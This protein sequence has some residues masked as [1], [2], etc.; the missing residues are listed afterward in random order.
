MK[1]ESKMTVQ[2][3]ENGLIL[4]MAM[5]M[6]TWIIAG[7]LYYPT[8]NRLMLR[9]M[10]IVSFIGTVV[11]GIIMQ[12]EKYSLGENYKKFVI[13]CATNFAFFIVSAYLLDERIKSK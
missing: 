13:A 3:I 11:A 1:E 2:Q 10:L 4:I 12:M 8:L 5:S 9:I 6:V 7:L